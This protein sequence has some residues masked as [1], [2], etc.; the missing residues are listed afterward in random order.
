[1][2]DHNEPAR[3]LAQSLGAVT[4]GR[5]AFPDGVEREM[6]ELPHCG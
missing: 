5:H 6:F 1:M 3:R 2:E 4:L